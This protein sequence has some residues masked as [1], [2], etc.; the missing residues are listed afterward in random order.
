MTDQTSP[1]SQHPLGWLDV[2]SPDIATTTAFL[3]KLFG[4]VEANRVDVEGN[5]Y[6]FLTDSGRP[7][8]GAEQIRPDQGSARWT[9]FVTAPDARSLIARAEAAGGK[10]GFPPTALADLG[11]IAM[12]TDPLGATLGV[13]QPLALVPASVETTAAPLVAA[14]LGTEDLGRT[15]A[16][17]REVFGW[18]PFEDGPP[19]DDHEPG[20]ASPRSPGRDFL[21][22]RTGGAVAELL[23]SDQGEWIPVFRD[24]RA[25]LGELAISLGGTAS[26]VDVDT[27]R[28]A[29]PAGAEFLL[30]GCPEPRPGN[31]T[32]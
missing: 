10:V 28:V 6:L 2:V 21:R 7:M 17:L 24:T 11:V 14:R 23:A 30:T 18:T 5:D 1:V 22:L 31:V 26:Q 20:A 32:A 25:G 3:E 16:F 29:D 15:S 19:A 9:V 12:V 4:W 8:H 27:I 13:W